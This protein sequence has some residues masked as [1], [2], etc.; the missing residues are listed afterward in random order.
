MPA[1][2]LF[3]PIRLREITLKN[4]VVVAPMHQYAAVGG[5]PTD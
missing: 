2:M 1:P 5:Y 4:R 3:T